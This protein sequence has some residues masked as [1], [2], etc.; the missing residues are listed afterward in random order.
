MLK[1]YAIAKL[2]MHQL[3][4]VVEEEQGHDWYVVRGQGHVPAC[5]GRM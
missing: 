3:V 4:V 2:H 5:W 1:Q